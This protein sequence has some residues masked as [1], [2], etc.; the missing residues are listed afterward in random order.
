MRGIYAPSKTAINQGLRHAAPQHEAIY[1][2]S[3]CHRLEAVFSNESTHSNYTPNFTLKFR[4]VHCCY[5]I[6]PDHLPQQDESW[7]PC[8]IRCPR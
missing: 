2:C 4:S 5:R 1:F 3:V 8:L 6:F 7:V